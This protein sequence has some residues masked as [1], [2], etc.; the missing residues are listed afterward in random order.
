MACMT[1]FHSRNHQLSA[2]EPADRPAG[3]SG[4]APPRDMAAHDVQEGDAGQEVLTIVAAASPTRPQPAQSVSA[5]T[6][7][8]TK[9]IAVERPSFR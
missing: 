1:R 2:D 9:R 4:D 3:G 7:A 5:A 8:P 6:A